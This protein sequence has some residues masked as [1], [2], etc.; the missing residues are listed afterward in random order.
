MSANSISKAGAN[1][2]VRSVRSSL[3]GH[4]ADCSL[5]GCKFEHPGA[6]RPQDNQN[7]FQALGN[8]GN[9]FGQ[10]NRNQ[11]RPAAPGRGQQYQSQ[12]S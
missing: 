6:N 3:I 1:L 4:D 10:G 5:D 8:Q 7:R 9:N 11:Q 12:N 2:E